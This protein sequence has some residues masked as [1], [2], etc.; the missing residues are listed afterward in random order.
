M[1]TT[2]KHIACMVASAALAFA[3]CPTAA[4]AQIEDDQTPATQEEIDAAIAAGEILTEMPEDQAAANEAASEVAALMDDEAVEEFSGSNRYDTSAKQ[5]VAGWESST[6]I[7]VAS[8]EKWPDALA[9]SSLAGALDCPLILTASDSLP[10]ET[11]AAIKQL[12]PSKAI[13]VGGTGVVSG[14]VVTSLKSLGVSK[15]KRLAGDNRYGTQLEIFEYGCEQGLWS[16]DGVIVACGD[17]DAFADALS[18]SPLAYVTKYPVF[19]TESDGTFTSEQEATIVKYAQSGYFKSSLIVGGTLRVTGTTE[20]FLWFA[21][22]LSSGSTHTS[23]RLSGDNRWETNATI[24]EY[25]VKNNLLSCEGAAFA[26]SATPYDAL[27]GGVL[28]GHLG[29]VLMLVQDGLTADATRAV[30]ANGGTTKV[31]FFGGTGAIPTKVRTT[32]LKALGLYGS[33][34]VL[35]YLDAGHGQDSSTVGVYD[36]GATGNGYKE[37]ELCQELT[38]LIADE[39]RNTYGIKCFVN[40]DGGLYKLRQA[41]AAELGCTHLVSIHFNSTGGTPAAT[42]SE[43]FIHTSVPAEGSAEFREYVHAG[44]IAGTTLTDRGKKFMNLAVCNGSVP[45]TLLEIAFIDNASDMAIYQSR[46]ATVAKE[47]ARGIYEGVNC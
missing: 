11:Q 31:K 33:S 15:V 26:S 27:G 21:S 34:D 47:I 14:N 46:K 12:S 4:F 23:T 18:V 36:S 42:G 6:W 43:S 20:G 28:Q 2:L 3:L 1:K 7:V 38:N 5:V 13:V 32:I 19:L 29:S 9:A 25:A 30:N 35:V 45:A 37:A 8:G 41:E 44:L 16:Q 39:L 40:D 22:Q 10:S 17:N 24:V